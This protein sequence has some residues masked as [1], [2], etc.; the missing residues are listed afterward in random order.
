MQKKCSAASYVMASKILPRAL[1]MSRGT[2][3]QPFKC[4]R[5]GRLMLASKKDRLLT[6]KSA[7]AHGHFVKAPT[8]KMWRIQ[9]YW[10]RSQ[11]PRTNIEPLDFSQHAD[12][13]GGCTTLQLKKTENT[14]V[15]GALQWTAMQANT[16]CALF[17]HSTPMQTDKLIIIAS[18]QD[19][20]LIIFIKCTKIEQFSKQISENHWV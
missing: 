5:N 17:L 6:K 16:H 2:W 10:N 9:H 19:Q 7:F 4:P 15:K 18:R 13:T 8:L 14:V 20:I 11:C 12:I 1:K 3:T